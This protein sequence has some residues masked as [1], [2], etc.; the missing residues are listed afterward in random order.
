M[1]G[2][3]R[4]AVETG[5]SKVELLA[6]PTVADVSVAGVEGSHLRVTNQ[7]KETPIPANA[8]SEALAKLLTTSKTTSIRRLRSTYSRKLMT[9]ACP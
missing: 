8:S 1:S 2:Y 3:A 7:P 9:L 6:I 5:G 4:A